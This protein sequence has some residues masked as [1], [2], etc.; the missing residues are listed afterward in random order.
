M[1]RFINTYSIHRRLYHNRVKKQKVIS[2]EQM[3]NQTSITA[4][5]LCLST[6]DIHGA[7]VFCSLLKNDYKIVRNAYLWCAYHGNISELRY[8]K[9][10]LD[11]SGV[12]HHDDHAF[13]IAC[14]RGYLSIAK[15]VY[16]TSDID[17]TENNN[18]ALRYSFENGQINVV[19]WLINIGANI[20]A[21]DDITKETCIKNNHL[22]MI[23]WLK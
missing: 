7:K 3:S 8:F 17:L 4:F 13:V 15:F 1:F 10:I 22:H 21:I 6:G 19:K 5:N 16:E 12:K 14:E 9:D 20:N 2:I 23:E 18:A 11:K